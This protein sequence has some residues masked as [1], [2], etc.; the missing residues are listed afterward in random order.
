MHARHSTTAREELDTPNPGL[1]VTAPSACPATPG[2]AQG[3]TPAEADETH[4]TRAP[5]SGMR[6]WMFEGSAIPR[7]PRRGD[8]PGLRAADPDLEPRE[9]HH[10]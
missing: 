5:A 4:L 3:P 6:H 1:R 2:S 9:A 7:A 8:P 10:L